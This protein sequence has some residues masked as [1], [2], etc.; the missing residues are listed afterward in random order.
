M[1]SRYTT[2]E[3]ENFWSHAPEGLPYGELVKLSPETTRLMVQEH[4]GAVSVLATTEPVA[5][6]QQLATV[7]VS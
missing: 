4:A 3:I 6:L 7:T 1:S 2:Q 5:A